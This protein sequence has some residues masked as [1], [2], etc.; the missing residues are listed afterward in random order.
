M[1][2]IAAMFGALGL[3]PKVHEG[4]AD[5]Y[6]FVA[7]SPLGGETPETRQRGQTLDELVALLAEEVRSQLATNRDGAAASRR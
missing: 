7:G 1:E 5:L 6:R 2:E 3:T 4:A